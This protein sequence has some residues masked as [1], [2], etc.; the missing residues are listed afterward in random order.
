MQLILQLKGK[1][2]DRT[3]TVEEVWEGKWMSGGRRWKEGTQ[4]SSDDTVYS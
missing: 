4:W 2:K 3:S 1:F